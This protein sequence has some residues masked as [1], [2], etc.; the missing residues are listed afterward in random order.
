VLHSHEI[1]K[2]T[3]DFNIP[4]NSKTR[5][6]FIDRVTALIGEV[7]FTLTVAVI[8]KKKHVEKYTEPADPY[9]IALGFCMERLQR[10]LNYGDGITCT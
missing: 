10:F 1:R 4:L 3:G 9:A 5:S 2:A 6:S 7:E 8:D